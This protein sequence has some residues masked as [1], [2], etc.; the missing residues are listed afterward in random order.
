MFDKYIDTLIQEGKCCFNL[1]EAQKALGKTA[2]SIS[3]AIAHQYAKGRIAKP[4]HGFY[5]IVPPEYRELGCIPPE[6]FIPYLM[7]YWGYRYYAAL[8]TAANYH[9]ASHQASFV[10]QVIINCKRPAFLKCGKFVIQFLT[11][12]NI[13]DASIMSRATPKSYINLSTPEATAFDLLLYPKASGG[14]NHIVTVL[15]ELQEAMDVKRLKE[16]INKLSNIACMQRLGYLL[17]HLGASELANILNEALLEHKHPRYIPLL[18][19]K[20]INH[21]DSKNK[22]WMIIENT[23]IESDI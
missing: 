22:K 13:T 6:Q 1:K 21:K 3:L 10:F 7:E 16:I 11:K 2:N 4:A 17:D 12:K 23:T 18:P 8:L 19:D 5:V 20:V 15:S 14:L 9:G